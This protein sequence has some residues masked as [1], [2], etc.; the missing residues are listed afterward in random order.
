MTKEQRQ[1]CKKLADGL[2]LSTEIVEVPSERRF[3]FRISGSGV[4]LLSLSVS[5]VKRLP[6]WIREEFAA[7]EKED[8]MLWG[9]LVQWSRRRLGI[10]N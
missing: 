7:P 1:F 9:M 4:E 5:E 3:S 6:K 2:T 10:G 8:P